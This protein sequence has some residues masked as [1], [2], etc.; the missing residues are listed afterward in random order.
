MTYMAGKASDISST[1]RKADDPPPSAEGGKGVAAKPAT[2]SDFAP[3]NDSAPFRQV[4]AALS[5]AVTT[6]KQQEIDLT[7]QADPSQKK[8]PP[9]TPATLREGG[10]G[11]GLLLEKPPPPEFSPFV[12]NTPLRST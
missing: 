3:V 2:S 6:T 8:R 7:S 4:A 5:A 9:L 10:P 1:I 11:E 12:I